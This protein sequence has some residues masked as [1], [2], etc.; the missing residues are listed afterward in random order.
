MTAGGSNHLKKV[1][2]EEPGY[3]DNFSSMFGFG[4]AEDLQKNTSAAR[5]VRQTVKTSTARNVASI[6]ND[7]AGKPRTKI[8]SG[9]KKNSQVQNDSSIS[10]CD[11]KKQVALVESTNEN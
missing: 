8:S 7:I 5:K 2:K 9:E 10:S 3:L 4:G 6:S 1:K 11:S